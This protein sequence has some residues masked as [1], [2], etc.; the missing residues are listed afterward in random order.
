[1]QLHSKL[2]SELVQIELYSGQSVG[3]PH[4]S[5]QSY[6]NVYEAYDMVYASL[7]DFNLKYILYILY[8]V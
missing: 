5:S 2:P 1:M 7:Q 8:Y 4:S 6:G 3:S